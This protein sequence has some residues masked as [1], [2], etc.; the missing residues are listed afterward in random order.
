MAEAK[1]IQ[2]YV[3]RNSKK[4]LKKYNETLGDL[5]DLDKVSKDNLSDD[6]KAEIESKAATDAL[7]SS[8][9]VDLTDEEIEEIVTDAKKEDATGTGT[10]TQG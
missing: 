5:A 3:V 6:L 4:I 2:A 9:L 1:E 7:T 10:E 8:D